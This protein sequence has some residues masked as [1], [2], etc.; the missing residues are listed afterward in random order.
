MTSPD[1]KSK[2][3]TRHLENAV[4]PESPPVVVSPD[5]A[6]VGTGPLDQNLPWVI[7][8]RIVG[9]ATTLQME[10]RNAMLIGRSDANGDQTA[11][12]DL[13]PFDA[14][15]KGVSRRHAVITVKE[16]RLHLRD[17]NSTNGTRLNSVACD[18][19][20]EYRLRHGDQLQFGH[21]HLQMTVAVVPTRASN[22]TSEVSALIIERSPVN[23][24]GRRIL[25]VVNEAHVGN[26]F[27][28]ALE[29]AGYIVVLAN[30][31]AQGLSHLLQTIPDAIVLDMMMPDMNAL[32]LVRY[33]RKQPTNQHIPVL[34]IGSTGGFQVNQAVEAGADVIL[35]K[36]VAVSDLLFALANVAVV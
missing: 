7:E 25:V 16:Q 32:D 10:V 19:G 36:P 14:Y 33:V 26:V 20:K 18:A 1:F 31:V 24:N 13:T 6:F 4:D 35:N 29:D 34:V 21:L 12:I 22:Q 8:F 11:D 15:S 27:Q 23:G 17:L 5:A 2:M 9:T 28:G 3:G 30:D